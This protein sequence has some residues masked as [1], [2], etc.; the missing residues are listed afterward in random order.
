MTVGERIRRLWHENWLFVV[1]VGGL[2]AA[3]LVLRTP[4]SPVK[5]AAVVEEM[6][7]SGRPAMVVFYS[8]T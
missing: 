4:A 7:G 3:F 6:L 8:N 2:T 1:L 5:T